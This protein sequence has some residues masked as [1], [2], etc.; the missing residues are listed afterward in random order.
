MA[1]ALFGHVGVTS[2]EH[3]HE[4]AVLRRRIS[5]L[6]NEVL[7]LKAQNDGLL[8]RLAETA[9]DGDLAELLESATR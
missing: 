1:K 9:H 2:P 7:R 6:E 8:A 5:D 3:A 4:V